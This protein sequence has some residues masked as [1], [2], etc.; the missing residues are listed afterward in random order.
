MQDCFENARMNETSKLDQIQIFSPEMSRV[1][2][3]K[4]R[5][6]ITM[7]D[8][9]VA[10][11]PTLRSIMFINF[12]QIPPEETPS[13]NELLTVAHVPSDSKQVAEG[14]L[15]RPQWDRHSCPVS[16]VVPFRLGLGFMQ[17]WATSQCHKELNSEMLAEMK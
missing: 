2:E 17:T 13:P 8:K 4:Q 16:Q 11:P 9:G 10:A 7:P 5:L 15:G 3:P 1:P 12:P 6:A 14:T